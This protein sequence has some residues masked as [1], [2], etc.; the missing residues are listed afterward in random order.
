M[1]PA[2]AAAFE[3]EP[4]SVDAIRLRRW[5]DTAKVV[6]LQTPPLSHFVKYLQEAAMIGSNP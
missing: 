1:T 3:A 6:G 2:E 5:D 4:F